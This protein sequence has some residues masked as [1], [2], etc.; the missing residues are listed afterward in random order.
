MKP[1]RDHGRRGHGR[2][3]PS[4]AVLA[5]VRKAGAWQG[6]NPGRPPRAA[7][8][9]GNRERRA[10]PRAGPQPEHGRAGVKPRAGI[11]AAGI[12]AAGAGP[13]WRTGA[14]IMAGPRGRI[15]RGPGYRGRH[16]GQAWRPGRYTRKANTSG[17]RRD[18]LAGRRARPGPGRFGS[19]Q[20]RTRAGGGAEPRYFGVFAYHYDTFLAI[21]DKTF[22]DL[23]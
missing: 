2:A 1:S 9:P 14:G 15:I 8:G 16:T 21:F 22:N 3:G 20:G 7:L 17:R 6:A 13:V 18:G 11:T 10:M 12:T 19:F 4:A 23:R 5:S